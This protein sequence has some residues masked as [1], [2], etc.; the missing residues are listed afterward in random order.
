MPL[1]LNTRSVYDAFFDPVRGLAARSAHHR[2]CPEFSDEDWLLFNLHRVLEASPSGRG[3]LQEH[4]PRFATQPSRSNYFTSIASERRRG[5]ARDV[6]ALLIAA[7]DPGNR[8]AAI[9]ELA[10]YRC[11]A[12]DGHWHAAATHDRREASGAKAP[13]G[14]FYS[15]DLHSHFLRHLAAAESAHEHDMSV[16]KRLKPAGLRQ[17]V[18]KGT[19]VLLVHD[20]AGIDF[21]FWKRC[22]QECAVY[23]LS[24]VK[25]GMVFEQLLDQEFDPADPRN[26]GVLADRRVHT[27][28]GLLLRIV[29]YRE[30]ATGKEYQFLTN[31]TDLPPG[32]VAEL[33]RRRWE[34]EKVFDE[35]K[36]KLAERKAWATSLVAKEV[37]G[38]LVAIAHNLMVLYQRHLQTGH[39]V[40]DQ[41]ETLRRERRAELLTREAEA[42][43]RSISSLVL[44]LRSA[45]QRSV[46]FIRWLRHALRENLA[47]TAAVPRLA[48]LMSSS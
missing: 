48:H 6:N 21:S 19:R 15:L 12:T 43:G 33:Y 41:A 29:V 11:F 14:H 18:P 22:R 7:G 5:V 4:G 45:T 35:L 34:I 37:Q 17:G 31:E 10:R 20:R 47:E 26:R 44:G 2:P 25:E 39:G 24:R 46:K 32:V 27:R 9:P 1:S 8:L 28:D 13:V 30:P 40:S 3:F 16:L 38:Q 42:Q 36:N 23:F